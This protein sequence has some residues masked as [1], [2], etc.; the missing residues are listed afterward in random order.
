MGADVMQIRRVLGMVVLAITLGGCAAFEPIPTSAEGVVQAAGEEDAARVHLDL[1]ESMIAQEQ[2]YAAL[3]HLE[4]LERRGHL[5]PEATYHKAEALRKMGRVSEARS[6]YRQLLVTELSGQ[7]HHGLGLLLASAD[8]AG[9]TVHLKQ[10]VQARPTDA[11]YR[12]D[13]GYAYLLIG[14]H[15]L[16]RI[17]F[18]TAMQLAPSDRRSSNNL[19]LTLLVEGRER[20]AA[21]IAAR[22]R[23]P[24]SDWKEIK[25]QARSLSRVVGEQAR[26]ES[27]KE[28]EK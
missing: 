10:A 8:P 24:A 22:S 27:L 23:V 18:S 14:R 1:I 3:A 17:E 9:A 2:Y 19:I 26:F 21:A 7:G 15:D 16:A 11:S 4:E 5:G 12:N 28:T 13:L 20:E 25:A 6:A